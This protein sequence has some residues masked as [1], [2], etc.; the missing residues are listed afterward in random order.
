MRYV[1]VIAALALAGCAATPEWTWYKAGAG[2]RDFAIDS[3]QCRAQAFGVAGAPL[4]QVAIVLSSCLEGKG[5][6]RRAL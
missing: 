6:E 1:I 5:W 2:P 3:G 4:M